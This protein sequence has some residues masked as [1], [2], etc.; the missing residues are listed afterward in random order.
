M[1]VVNRRGQKFRFDLHAA[2]PSAAIFRIAGAQSMLTSECGYAS[3]GTSRHRLMRR[4]LRARRLASD[5][6]CAPTLISTACASVTAS[7]QPYQS[8]LFL[9]KDECGDRAG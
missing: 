6:A 9:A 1:L 5:V 4:L 7:R 2:V 8:F 3:D